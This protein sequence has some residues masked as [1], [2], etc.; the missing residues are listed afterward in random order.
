MFIYN[1][2]AE[3]YYPT[4]PYAWCGNNPITFIDANG[5]WY[6]F[7]GMTNDKKTTGNSQGRIFINRDKET[8]G[9]RDEN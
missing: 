4:S 6:D 9:K 7:S 5:C 3:K 2:L 8:K 1:P